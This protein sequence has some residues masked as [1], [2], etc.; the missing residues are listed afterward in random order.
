MHHFISIQLT[1]IDDSHIYTYNNDC[2]E[3][4]EIVITKQY[5]HGDGIMAL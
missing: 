3:C 5:S 4:F 2:V 1:E